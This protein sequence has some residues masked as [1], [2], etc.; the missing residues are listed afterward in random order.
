MIGIIKIV[1]SANFWI[2]AVI[3][4]LGV[5]GYLYYNDSIL[6]WKKPKR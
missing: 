6:N 2:G 3:S 4:A 1:L 5:V